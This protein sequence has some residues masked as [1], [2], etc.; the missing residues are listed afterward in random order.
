MNHI[1]NVEDWSNS[2]NNVYGLVADLYSSTLILIPCCNQV[3]KVWIQAS[4]Q[5]NYYTDNK[6]DGD[7]V[8]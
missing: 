1:N 3:S 4:T 2:D 6:Y 5:E 7:V 8:D